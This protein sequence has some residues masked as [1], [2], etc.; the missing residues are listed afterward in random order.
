MLLLLLACAPDP[1]PS[2]L[3]VDSPADESAPAVETGPGEGSRPESRADSEDSPHSEAPGDTGPLFDDQVEILH[4]TLRT[5]DGENAGTDERITVCLNESDCFVMDN[6]DWN[7]NERAAVDVF[8]TEGLSLSRADL[9]SV[10]LQINDGADRWQPECV[11]VSIDGEPVHCH[12]GLTVLMG[13]DTSASERM[14]WTDPAGLELACLGCFDAPLTHGPIVGA[15]GADFTHLWLRTDATRRVQVRLATSAAGLSA[16][17]PVAT[18]WPLAEDDLTTT[19]RLDGLSPNTTY[20]YDL[21]IEGERLGPWSF[22][23]A[24]AEGAAGKLRFA[25]GSC[26]KTDDQPIF[27]VVSRYAP[28]LFLFV[29]D[30]HYANTESIGGHRQHYRHA[31]SRPERAELMT[32]TPILATW[33]DHDFTGN[34]TEGDAPGKD[35][36][37]RAFTEHWGNGAYGEASVPG[38]YSAHTVGDV[39]FVL[40]DDRYWRGVD[41]SFLGADQSAWLVDTLTASDATFKFVVSGSQ[42][43]SE[44]TG[45]SWGSYPDSQAWLMEQAAAIEGVVFLSGDIHRSELRE[46]AA[47]PGGYDVPELTS[48]P[49]ANDTSTCKT[50]SE[51]VTCYDD[52]PSFV[53]VEVDTARADPTLEVS[54]LDIDGALVGSWTIRRSQLTP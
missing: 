38:V 32:R 51:L 12:D 43:T 33:D 7:D 18:V 41:G 11:A 36:A 15:T 2:D 14:E 30:N 47:A 21:E 37:L 31:H 25:F 34:N 23:T 27:D 42:M 22:T 48:S 8:V 35:V 1:K 13:D 26:T 54:V 40:L 44:G 29:G 24:A 16:A 46:V 3:L 39:L 4:I 10:T 49:M 19:V 52:G 45:D 28:D 20:L 50:S 5:H 17:A 6:A 9:E 53:M